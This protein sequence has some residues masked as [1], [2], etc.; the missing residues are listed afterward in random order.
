MLAFTRTTGFRHDSFPDA[1]AAVQALAAQDGCAVDTTEDPGAFADSTLSAYSA[2]IFLLTTGHILD[3]DQQRSFERYIASGN[4]FVG[5]HSAADTEYDWHWYGG[6]M[7]AY[8]ASHP[9]IQPATILREDA[10][11]PSTESLPDAW[12]RTDE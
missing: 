3:S 10:T 8:F 5:V 9:V 12:L 1:I 7:G 6:L 4:G 11:H 2:D